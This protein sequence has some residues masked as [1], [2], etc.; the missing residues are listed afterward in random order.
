MTSRTI[1]ESPAGVATPA[2]TKSHTPGEVS[3]LDPR[4]ADRFKRDT[5]LDLAPGLVMLCYVGSI[6]HGTHIPNTNP[7]AV[8]DIDLMGVFIPPADYTLGL[9][10]WD[11]W[12]MKEGELDVVI[13]SL[14]KYVGLLLKS[15]PN[16]L[17]TLY[18]EDRHYLVRAAAF[19]GL[20]AERDIFAAKTAYD[21]FIGYARAQLKKMLAPQRYEGYMGAKR[22][23]LVDRYGYDVKNAA[24]LIRL[25]RMCIEF[26]EEGTLHVDRTGR[27]AEQLKEIKR[28]EW[29]VEEIEF[30][31]NTLFSFADSALGLTKLPRFPNYARATA[32][33]VAAHEAHYGMYILSGPREAPRTAEGDPVEGPHDV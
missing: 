26:L 28:G 24:H 25:M 8:D 1:P 10:H 3:G 29:R 11:H 32:L 4:I 23:E 15:N 18:S 12:T 17:G 22:K 16:V 21:A 30:V 6:A 14:K 7:D 20:Q 5:G 33:V 31:A 13:Y 2:A 19:R 27:D 9:G